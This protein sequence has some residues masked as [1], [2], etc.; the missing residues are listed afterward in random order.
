MVCISD[1]LPSHYLYWPQNHLLIK[2]YCPEVKQLIQIFTHSLEQ[3]PDINLLIYPNYFLWVK[4]FG[5]INCR[6]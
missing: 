6:L 4:K 2:I 1:D 5:W 3:I